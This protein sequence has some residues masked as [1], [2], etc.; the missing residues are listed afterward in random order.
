MND[1]PITVITAGGAGLN[2]R[3]ATH[4]S[5][6]L[7]PTK[8]ENP[9]SPPP[10]P[11]VHHLELEDATAHEEVEAIDASTPTPYG[12][13]PLL[14]QPTAA[15]PYADNPQ[16]IALENIPLPKQPQPDTTRSS[17]LVWLFICFFGI[18]MSFVCYGLLLEY[19]T[20]GGRKLHEMSFLF[21][22]SG[23]YTLTAAAGRYVRDETRK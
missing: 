23:L 1:R 11:T 13:D 16:T 7:K 6:S 14:L 12:D 8:V 15:R 18:M 21:V 22:T 20:S 3:E 19:T 9:S 2:K 10:P 5:R 17:E 4:T